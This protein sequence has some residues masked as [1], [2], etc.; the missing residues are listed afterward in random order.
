LVANFIEHWAS[1][2]FVSEKESFSFEF[3]DTFLETNSRVFLWFDTKSK[4]FLRFL[5]E[6][7]VCQNLIST[8]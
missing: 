7:H 6:L 1:L 8:H 5:N 4:L 2:L 3:F